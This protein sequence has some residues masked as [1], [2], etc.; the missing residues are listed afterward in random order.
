VPKRSALARARAAAAD[1]RV[2][3]PDDIARP[4]RL[5][6]PLRL[7]IGGFRVPYEPERYTVVDRYGD[8]DVLADMGDLPFHD[9]TVDAI[10]ASHVLEHC[11]M[12]KVPDVLREWLRVMRPGGRAIIRVPDFN[13]VARYWLT[14]PD[15]GWAEAMVFGLQS[16]E[17]EYHKAAFTADLLRGDLE[18]TGWKVLRI[19]MRW[20]HNQETLQAVATKAVPE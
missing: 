8:P 18:G 10:W 1:P 11:D 9:N 14:G 17:G 19:E 13:Y 6:T 16:D 15:R 2:S 7:D 5:L 3:R 12:G 20:T 4:D